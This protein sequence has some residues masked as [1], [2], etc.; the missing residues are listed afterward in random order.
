MKRQAGFTLIETMVVVAI[1][2]V[3][4]GVGVPAMQD[5]IV[6]QRIKSTTSDLFVASRAVSPWWN[7]ASCR[8]S[9]HVAAIG[10]QLVVRVG[11]PGRL[12]RL[13]AFGF[14]A[15]QREDLLRARREIVHR[16][17]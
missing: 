4:A 17:L 1:I 5:L 3:L 11:L 2:I 14:L 15:G 8:A 12:D 13:A 16:F 7:A 6:N 9:R 10:F